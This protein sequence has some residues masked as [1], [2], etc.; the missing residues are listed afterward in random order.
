MVALLCIV[1]SLGIA[2]FSG[3]VALVVGGAICFSFVS[4]ISF[5]F[6]SLEVSTTKFT[7]NEG[8]YEIIHFLAS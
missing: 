2:S 6:M 4:F 8:S 3:F 1:L 7:F 5:D